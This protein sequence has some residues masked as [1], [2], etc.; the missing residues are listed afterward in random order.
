[1]LGPTFVGRQDIIRRIERHWATNELLPVLIVY[2]HRRMGKSSILRNLDQH[3]THNTLLVYL[4][5]Q[6]VP[7]FWNDTSNPSIHLPLCSAWLSVFASRNQLQSGA[8][9][10]YL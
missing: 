9:G 1:M 5:M 7:F 6:G 10:G 8:Y 4:D 2:G 3:T